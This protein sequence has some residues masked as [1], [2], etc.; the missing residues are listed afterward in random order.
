MPTCTLSALTILLLAAL[1]AY[2][3]HQARRNRVGDLSYKLRKY[4]IAEHNAEQSLEN[5]STF[6]K[7]SLRVYS[8]GSMKRVHHPALRI[9][10]FGRRNPPSRVCITRIARPAMI[11]EH[12]SASKFSENFGMNC[13]A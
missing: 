12:V 11:K 4:E 6:I 1:G 2:I 10:N 8:D 5:T 13:S 7:K 9:K 3:F